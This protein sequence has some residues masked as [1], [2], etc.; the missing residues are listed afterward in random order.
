MDGLHGQY[1]GFWR[2]YITESG[3]QVSFIDYAGRLLLIEDF[4]ESPGFSGFVDRLMR[5]GSHDKAEK[6][7]IAIPQNIQY[8]NLWVAIYGE[9]IE[10]TCTG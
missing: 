9:L 10:F 8:N 7:V 2:I 4:Y 1:R 6:Y 5:N 3:Y